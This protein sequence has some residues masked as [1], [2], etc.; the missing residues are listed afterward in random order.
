[1]FGDLAV[2]VMLKDED[3]RLDRGRASHGHDF[4]RLTHVPTGKSRMHPGPLRNINQDG[5]VRAWLSE[6]EAE[7]QVE[8]L[9]Q[10]IIPDHR[11][12]QTSDCIM[13]LDD[14]LRQLAAEKLL[15][16]FPDAPATAVKVDQ[17]AVQM[18]LINLRFERAGKVRLVYCAGELF[19]GNT[20]SVEFAASGPEIDG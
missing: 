15:S 13:R 4:I 7:I 10:Y 17:L 3:I 8:G 18:Q 5:L 6:I 1:M 19:Y 16:A 14:A 9:T 2:G 12:H 20:V 11:P